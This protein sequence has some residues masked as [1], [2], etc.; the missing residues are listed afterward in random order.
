MI[1]NPDLPISVQL[2]GVFVYL[3]LIG[4]APTQAPLRVLFLSY[5]T[6]AGTAAS[7]TL[8]RALSEDDVIT[9]CGTGSGLHRYFRAFAAQ[10][11]AN[12]G[13]ETWFMPVSAPSGTAQTKF[14]KVLEAPTGAVVGSTGTAAAA[15]GFWSTWIAGKQYDSTIANGA[16][17]AT[18]MQDMVTQIQAD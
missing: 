2:P 4:A 16:T 5:K 9:K 3:S 17:Y 11:G 14:I 18:I 13:A 15:A 6:S 7:G 12:V 1:T 8:F 10:G